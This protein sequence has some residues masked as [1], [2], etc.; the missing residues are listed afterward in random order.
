MFGHREH[1][2]CEGA[3]EAAQGVVHIDA[4]CNSQGWRAPHPQLFRI[5]KGVLHGGEQCFVDDVRTTLGHAHRVLTPWMCVTIFATSE[6]QERRIR[7]CTERPDPPREDGPRRTHSGIWLQSL[8]C[9][10]SCV[11]CVVG[12]SALAVSTSVCIGHVA[13]E[14]AHVG[15]SLHGCNT[16]LSGPLIRADRQEHTRILHRARAIKTIQA[17]WLHASPWMH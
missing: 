17:C 2:T 8:S 4:N 14:S 15:S 1:G 10:H 6:V 7:Q 11:A 13:K 9:A 3:Q 12:S 5:T 16:V